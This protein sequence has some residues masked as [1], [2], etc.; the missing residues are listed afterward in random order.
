MSGYRDIRN[1]AILALLW[2]TVFP[3]VEIGLSTFPPLLLMAFRFDVAGLLMVSYVV[4]VADDWLPTSRGDLLAIVAG[5]V[6]WT[7]IGNGVWYVGQSLT[8]SV[9][10][11]LTTSLIPILTAGFSWALLPEERLTPLS[12]AG[13]GMAFPGAL[14]MM[15]PSGT[16]TFTESLLGK[17]ILLGGA[18]G[19]ALSSVLIRYSNTSLSSPVQTAWSAALGAVLLHILSLFSGEQWGGDLPASAG[20]AI[21]YLGVMSTV[22]AYLLYF[23][24]LER[25]PAIEL[26]LVMYLVPVVAVTAG[27]LLFGEPVTPTVVGGFLVV[28]AGFSLMKRREIRVELA[29]W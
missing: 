6:L 10:S 16:L 13:L 18:A 9:F 15:V 25:R 26:T 17:V 3:V 24:L 23:S 27:W 19:I 22:F 29:R 11:G 14:L 2:G 5:G 20:L 1:F 21:I 8:S 28:A 4:L 12:I 7:M